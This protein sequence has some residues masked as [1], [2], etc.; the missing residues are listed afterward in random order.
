MLFLLFGPAEHR[1][2][3]DVRTITEVLPLVDVAPVRSAP[4]GV[5]GVF[6]YRGAPVPA[7]DMSEIMVGRPA[8]ARVSTRLVLVDYL[9]RGGQARTL[10]LIAERATET[11]RRDAS[12][13]VPQGVI[14]ESARAARV[15]PD[16][17]GG[18]IEW[19]DPQTVLPDA[20]RDALFRDAGA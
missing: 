18:L 5:R 3:V 4:R 11:V 8:P 10:G 19:I 16:A 1:C 15:A 12:E 17:G 6:F 14:G 2:A 13:F 7:V 20:V 9:D